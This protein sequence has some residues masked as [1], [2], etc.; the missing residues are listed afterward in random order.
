MNF[1]ETKFA[2]IHKPTNKWISLE[3][4]GQLGIKIEMC[5][6][7]NF[8]TSCLYK[9]EYIIKEDLLRSVTNGEKYAAQNFLEFELV[10]IEIE[11]KTK[12]R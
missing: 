8:C 2:Y 11:Y 4:T 12:T 5:L 9:T 3:R 10:E 7:D 1:K 6:L